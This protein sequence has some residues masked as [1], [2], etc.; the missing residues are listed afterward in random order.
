MMQC[1]GREESKEQSSPTGCKSALHGAMV[2]S[3]MQPYNSM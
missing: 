3:L 2:H 1:E